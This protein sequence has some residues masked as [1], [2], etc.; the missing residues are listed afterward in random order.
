MKYQMVNEKLN[1][2]SC[3]IADLTLGQVTCILNQFE[4]D[5]PIDTLTLFYDKNADIVV[6]NKDNENFNIY[7]GL[8]EAFLKSDRK[9]AQ[10][11]VDEIPSGCGETLEVLRDAKRARKIKEELRI[12]GHQGIVGCDGTYLRDVFN[13]IRRKSVGFS[14][15]MFLMSQAYTYGVIQGKRE[16]RARRKRGAA[17]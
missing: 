9:K 8:A 16:E 4:D 13:E 7:L 3:S 5:A 11:F 17:S 12:N 2:A 10:E 15:P 14:H 1:I 6:L